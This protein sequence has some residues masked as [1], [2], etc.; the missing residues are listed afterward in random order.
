MTDEIRGTQF[1]MPRF[2]WGAAWVSFC[3][4]TSRHRLELYTVNEPCIVNR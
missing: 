2:P 3:F 1:G 4:P